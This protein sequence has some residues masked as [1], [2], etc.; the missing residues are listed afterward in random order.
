MAG[1]RAFLPYE[2]VNAYER[3]VAALEDASSDADCGF[4][5]YTDPLPACFK[6]DHEGLAIFDCCLHL[7][8]WKARGSSAKE[9]VNILVHIHEAFRRSDRVLVRST[10]QVSYFRIEKTSATLL[11][12]VHFDYGPEQDAHPLF[13][14]Q[15]SNEPIKLSAEDEEGLEFQ[16]ARTPCNVVCFKNARIPTSDMTF[17]SVLLCLAADHFG[18]PF[19]SEFMERVLDL[20]EKMPRADFQKLKASIASDPDHLRS[21]HWFAHMLRP[22]QKAN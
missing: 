19:F 9:R 16:F 7:T 15:I 3:L 2:V 11:Q 22:P 17:P 5:K 21:S 13:H 20:Q 6:F 14:A 1:A 12:S 4:I 10:V 18:Q 8:E